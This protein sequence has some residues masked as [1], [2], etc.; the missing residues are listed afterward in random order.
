MK[1]LTL[2]FLPLFFVFSPA[3]SMAQIVIGSSDMPQANVGYEFTNILNVLQLDVQQTGA[4]QTWN[5]SNLTAGSQET[6]S[7]LSFSSL[8]LPVRLAFFNSGNL[9]IN[10]AVPGL[11]SLPLPIPI[12]NSGTLI[13][14]KT[15]SAFIHTGFTFEFSGFPFPVKYADP[16]EIYKFP[17]EF[18]DRD[19]S[20]AFFNIQLPG[21]GYYEQALIRKVHVD[22]H[23]TLITPADTFEVLRVRTLILREDSIYMD[24]LGQGIRTPPEQEVTYEWLARNEGIPVM[25]VS[26]RMVAGNFLPISGFFIGKPA[27]S[28]PT[29]TEPIAEKPE[30]MKIFPS[31]AFSQLNIQYN[32]NFNTRIMLFNLNGKLVIEK[33]IFAGS[34]IAKLNVSGLSAGNYLLLVQDKKGTR[35]ARVSVIK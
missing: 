32:F 4:N 31:P 12:P 16:D 8:P 5:F 13:I 20:T 35:Q 15:S 24:T 14:N 19:S 28:N 9:A 26:G 2:I 34:K 21:L 17:L 7:F 30:D 3:R 1:I 29:L 22:G 10:T 23:G 25:S 27:Q 6:D 18:T 11:D 33:Q